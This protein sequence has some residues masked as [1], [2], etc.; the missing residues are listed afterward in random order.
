MDFETN[1]GAAENALEHERD[2]GRTSL[3]LAAGLV[4]ALAAGGLWTALVM[5]TDREI[6]Y[7]A[8]GVGLLVGF[9]MSRV[10]ANRTRRLAFA[11][12]LFA[13]LGLAAGKV[14]IYVGSTNAVAQQFEEDQDVLTS[15]VAWHLYAQ[16]ELDPATLEQVDAADAAGDTLS[17]VIWA[18][19][20]TQAETRLAGMSQEEKHEIAVATSRGVL[21]NMGIIGG[22]KAQLSLFDLLWV[23]LAVGTAFQMMGPG[24]EEAVVEEAVRV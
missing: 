18:A 22:I 3:S 11:A 15:A 12:A 7:A 23:F 17:D 14:F 4:A 16:R 8:W 2:D 24:K 5:L 9:A 19:M 10:T 21:Q 1:V 13:L 20:R 6:G